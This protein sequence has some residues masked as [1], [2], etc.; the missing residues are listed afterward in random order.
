MGNYRDSIWSIIHTVLPSGEPFDRA[1][2]FGAGDGW[3]ARRMVERGKVRELQA[4]DVKE[5]PNALYPMMIY[6][7]GALPFSDR[8]FTFTYSIDVL[9]HCPDPAAQLREVLRCTGRYFL[10]KDHTYRSVMGRAQLCV[11]DELG[12][13]RFGVPSLYQYQ[14]GWAWDPVFSECGFTRRQLVHPAGCHGGILGALTNHL[15]FVALWE[16]TS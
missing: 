12:N 16:R 8:K 11:L 15:Q 14:R 5:R 9:H 10:L 13:R 7:G 2:D 1:L 3:F 4:V 6:G